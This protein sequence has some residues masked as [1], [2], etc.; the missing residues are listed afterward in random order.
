MGMEVVIS[1]R[2]FGKKTMPLEVILDEF[3]AYGEY[4]D[5]N[6]IPNQLGETEF[7]AYL[8]NFIGRGFSVVWTPTETR[9]IEMCLPMQSTNDELVAFCCAIER[10]V[11]YW[12]GRL[13]VNGERVNPEEWLSG[14]RA[15]QTENHQ[16]IRSLAK[17]ILDGEH[18]NLVLP[19]AMWPLAIGREE[20]EK[21]H[22]NPMWFGRWLHERQVLD[23]C[24]CAPRFYSNGKVFLG[25][26]LCMEKVN[27]IFPTEPAV[28]WWVKD[29]Q[30]GEDLTCDLWRVW[31]ALEAESKPLAELD[32]EEFLRRLPPDR[33]SRYDACHIFVKH[34]KEEDIRAMAQAK[35]EKI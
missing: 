18:D 9:K 17:K 4:V 15:L 34:L 35:G 28:P 13:Q 21:M 2:L 5:D 20:A 12:G 33:V 24:Y 27:Y 11:Q 8:P 30:T 7:V 1:Q 6:L 29:P 32:Y 10:M 31:L 25:R 19:C 23:A 26:F 16:L 14:I 22:E 3:L